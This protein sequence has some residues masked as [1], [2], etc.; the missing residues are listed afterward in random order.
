MITEI[1]FGVMFVGLVVLSIFEA[2]ADIKAKW[3]K[4][5]MDALKA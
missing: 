1:A 4:I 3:R 5:A 2:K